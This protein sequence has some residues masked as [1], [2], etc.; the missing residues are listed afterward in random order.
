MIKKFYEYNN[1]NQYNLRGLKEGYWEEYY[2]NG[3]LHEKGEYKEGNKEGIWIWSGY[4]GKKH[5][6]GNYTRSWKHG[7]WNCYVNNSLIQKKVFNKSRE[8]Y[9]FLCDKGF[10]FYY[11]SDFNR[12]EEWLKLSTNELKRLKKITNVNN[13]KKNNKYFYIIDDNLNFIA[14]L[15]DDYFYICYNGKYTKYDQLLEVIKELKRLKNN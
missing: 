7:C 1:I 11:D 14:K 12:N 2:E 8:V 10:N 3:N 13:K 6:K 4:N 5:N 15:K 9:S